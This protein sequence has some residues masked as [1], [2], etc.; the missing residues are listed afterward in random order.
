[1]TG[2]RAG[3]RRYLRRHDRGFTLL[4]VMIALLVLSIGL[5]GL[6]A[7]QT[8]AL[9]TGQAADMYTRAVLAV[10]DMSERM[11][12]NPAGVAA[13]HYDIS[14]RSL[15]GRGTATG[16]AQADLAAWHAAL[17]RLPDSQ[18]EIAPC[19]SGCAGTPLYSLTVWWNPARDPAVRG[20]RC[21]PRTNSDLR[22]VRL[23]L[24]R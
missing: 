7:L 18:G 3:R 17:A 2:T 23:V 9:R 11:R 19:R 16:T 22:C 13:G 6:A 21:P 10:T 24:R 20:T 4:E 1:M 12:A 15:S 8:T 5:L 14:R